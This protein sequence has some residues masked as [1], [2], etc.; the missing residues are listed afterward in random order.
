MTLGFWIELCDF[1][2][3]ILILFIFYIFI[4]GCGGC[5][6]V[7]PF[8]FKSDFFNVIILIFKCDNNP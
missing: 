6:T 5:E 4:F 2:F 8:L 3:H 7:T 1:F